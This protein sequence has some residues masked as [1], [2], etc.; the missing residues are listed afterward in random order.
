MISEKAADF[1]LTSPTLALTAGAFFFGAGSASE[2][3]S[4]V[5]ISA[6]EGFLAAVGFLVAAGFLAAGFL[7]LAGITTHGKQ[8]KIIKYINIPR[9]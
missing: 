1:L 9:V 2:S 7:G 4:I 3:L 8:E 6:T 5:I